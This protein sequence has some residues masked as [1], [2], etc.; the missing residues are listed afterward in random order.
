MPCLNQPN[1]EARRSNFCSAHVLAP[2]STLLGSGRLSTP[3][4]PPHRQIL[5]VSRQKSSTCTVA[6]STYFSILYRSCRAIKV[7]RAELTLQSIE[8]L[9]SA[10]RPAICRASFAAELRRR[11]HRRLGRNAVM[12]CVVQEVRHGPRMSNN[13]VF[14]RFR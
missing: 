3:N 7:S 4:Q 5:Q 6:R 12:S 8:N 10:S 9:Q 2:T 11:N 1:Q 13:T 14:D